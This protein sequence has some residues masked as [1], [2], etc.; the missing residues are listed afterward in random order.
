MTNLQILD[1]ICLFDELIKQAL[2]NQPLVAHPKDKIAILIAS[3]LTQLA[4]SDTGIAGNHL[5]V[6]R[7]MQP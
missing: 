2:F 6:E 4:G 7:R 5:F 3:N 1:G